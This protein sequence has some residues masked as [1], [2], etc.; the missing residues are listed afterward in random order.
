MDI[1][2]FGGL[3]FSIQFPIRPEG[4][5]LLG[6]YLLTTLVILFL[7]RHSIFAMRR[8][9]WLIFLGLGVLTLILSIA[10]PLRFHRPDF[11]PVPNLPQDTAMP[12]APLLA[13]VP[14]L[15]AALWLGM[16]PAVLLSGFSALIQAGLQSGQITQRYEVV[17][18]GLVASFLIDQYYRGKAAATLRRPLAASLCGSLVAWAMM[19][20]SFFVYT[21]GSPLEALNYAWPLYL[22]AFLPILAQGFL[23]GLTVEIINVRWPRLRRRK[24]VTQDPAWNRTLNR[25]LLVP[26]IAFTLIVMV[27]LL[28][29]VSAVALR[30]ATAQA[31]TQMSRDAQA[32]ASDVAA[33]LRNGQ[34]LLT[35]IAE[36]PVLQ[37]GSA[38]A[39]STQL[40]S[41]MR[42]GPFFEQLLLFDGNGQLMSYAPLDQRPAPTLE[43]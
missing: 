4:M 29:V 11:Q 27:L 2:W 32:A 8:R 35:G 3:N 25:R 5:I 17:A 26:F 33:F 7:L 15:L 38:Q 13:A 19:L 39:Q 24:E 34:S 12:A 6:I 37:T 10:L 21:P 43:E 20:P 9:E 40:T 18:Y 42:Q 16:G 30:Q 31:V 14:L 23:S 22:G 28:A 36:E 1:E 41:A